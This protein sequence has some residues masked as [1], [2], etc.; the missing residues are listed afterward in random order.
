MHVVAALL[1][2]QRVEKAGERLPD[3]RQMGAQ[4]L[5]SFRRL[6][7]SG[8]TLDRF[9]V[10]GETRTPL[11][12]TLASVHGKFALSP[13]NG[14]SLLWIPRKNNASSSGGLSGV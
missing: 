4:L 2:A 5:Y 9:I 14:D 7:L 10:V 6:P 8:L 13:G 11:E 1:A 3:A 12:G